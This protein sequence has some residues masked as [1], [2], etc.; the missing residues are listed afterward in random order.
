MTSKNEEKRVA[1]KLT[2]TTAHKD[3]ERGLNRH[4][5]FKTSNHD[6]G[7]E[8]VQDTFMKTWKYILKGGKIEIMKSFLYHVLN[9][10]IIDDYRKHKTTSLDSLI[11]KGFE[12]SSEGDDRVFNILDGKIAILLI[13]RLPTKYQNIMRLRYIQDLTIKEIS[14]ITGQSKNTVAVQI[15]RGLEK[16]KLLYTHSMHSRT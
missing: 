13:P 2:L 11:E 12:P 8:L 10:L 9:G 7:E 4:A 6:T 15:H 1:Q 5:Y 16:L 3:Y 14:A